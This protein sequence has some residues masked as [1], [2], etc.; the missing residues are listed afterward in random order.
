MRRA[1]SAVRQVRRR[2]VQRRRQLTR[3]AARRS[4][5]GAPLR[6]RH[7]GCAIAGGLLRRARPRRRDRPRGRAAAR[8]PGLPSTTAS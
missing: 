8:T 4:P 2:Q 6:V 5:A 7:C 3:A 1:L